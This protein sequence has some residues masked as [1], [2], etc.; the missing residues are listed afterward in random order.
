MKRNEI[1]VT[2]DQVRL[3]GPLKELGLYTVAIH[4]GQDIEAEL[5]VWVVPTVTD[6]PEATREK[7]GDRQAS[8]P[9]KAAKT[10]K[11]EKK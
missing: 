4:L 9:E 1:T 5:K 10:D 8:K 11:A 7:P 2:A 6:E 3:K